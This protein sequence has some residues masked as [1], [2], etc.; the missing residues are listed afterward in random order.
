[1]R[2][3]IITW[4]FTL[5]HYAGDIAV[6]LTCICVDFVWIQHT[7]SIYI[8]YYFFFPKLSSTFLSRTKSYNQNSETIP[9]TWKAKSCRYH[10]MNNIRRVG[11]VQRYACLISVAGGY[12]ELRPSSAPIRVF[13]NW[14][15]CG[16]EKEYYLYN[17]NQLDALFTF[18]LFQ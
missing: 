7:V 18:N 9:L 5:R 2:W 15:G 13:T 11:T 12:F 6:G 1:M 8:E 16:S 14:T 3:W 10:A 17:K 4:F